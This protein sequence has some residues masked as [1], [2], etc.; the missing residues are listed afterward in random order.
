VLVRLGTPAA[1]AGKVGTDPLGDFLLALLD[2]RGVERPLVLRD[3]AAPTSASV[4][5][6][7]GEGE[8][9]FLHLPGANGSLTAEE[10]DL[11][12]LLRAAWLHVAG[13]LV[14]PALDGEPLAG[15][16]A[17]ARRR[18]VRTSLTPVWDASGRWERVRPCLPH[19]D[20][21]VGSLAEGRAITGE[22]EPERVAAALG[23]PDVVLTDG[24]NGCW[25][26]G[27]GAL[28]GCPVE[29]V[30]GTGAGDAFAAGVLFGMLAG[31][32]LERAARLANAVG[33]LAVTRVGA[34]EGVSGLDDALAL[35]GLEGP[36]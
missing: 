32:P 25:A 17:E 3:P 22:A 7:D 24:A 36:A 28:P 1:V 6:V 26:S 2:E 29:A 8:R 15:L 14:L 31:W 34:V 4:V 16:L 13:A 23:V 21:F 33:A 12:A 11:D 18:G 19:L 5:L 27:A 35:A 9:T 30:D 10:L 20:V